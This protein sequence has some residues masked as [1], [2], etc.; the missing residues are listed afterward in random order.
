MSAYTSS[1]IKKGRVAQVAKR[2]ATLG[3]PAGCW[4]VVTS[5]GVK[6]PDPPGMNGG[7]NGGSQ[8]SSSTRSLLYLTLVLRVALTTD[9]A[10]LRR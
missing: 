7:S 4:A 6:K 5:D 9:D 8:P 3:I 2:N 1:D 10:L